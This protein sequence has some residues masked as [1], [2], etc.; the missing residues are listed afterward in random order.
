MRVSCPRQMD[1]EIPGVVPN[2]NPLKAAARRSGLT[3]PFD[4]T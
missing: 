1:D 2:L 4:M 3:N